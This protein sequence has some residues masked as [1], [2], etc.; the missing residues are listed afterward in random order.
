MY[1]FNFFLCEN[2]FYTVSV[3]LIILMELNYFGG[4]TFISK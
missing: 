3:T 2:I 4:I 1:I